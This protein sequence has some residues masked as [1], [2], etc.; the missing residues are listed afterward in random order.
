[1]TAVVVVGGV[2]QEYCAF[3]EWNQI[4]G[5]A[6]R[7]AFALSSHV[8]QITLRTIL[9]DKDSRR[10]IPNFEA[11]GV[12]VVME[13]GTQ[14]IAFDYLH[15]LSDPVIFPR[16]D[17]IVQQPTFSV[18]AEVAI[19]FGM[20]EC[21]PQVSADVCVYDPQSPNHPIGFRQTGGK[22]KRLAIVANEREILKL[23]GT[24]DCDSA[25]TAVLKSE[26]AEIV[27][28]KRGLQGARVFGSAGLLGDVPAYE[29][30]TVF[31]IGSGDV[32]V[33]AFTLAWAVSNLDPIQ[34]ADFASK[35]VAGYV[36]T[37]SLPMISIDEAKSI[38]RSPVVLKPGRVYLA[39]PFRELG[40][41]ILIDEVRSILR[42]LGLDV[43]SPV[44]DIGR[45]PA[46]KVVP[47]D[48]EALRGCDAV[49]AIL[50]GSSPGTLFEVGYAVRGDKPVFCVAQNMRDVDTKLPRGAGCT[51]HPDLISALHLLAWRK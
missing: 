38:A 1:M 25:A 45:G 43:F 13:T 31:T 2:Y 33:A 44:H 8:D 21:T 12:D 6:G 28:V 3:P 16:P 29:T 15:C 4:Y 37:S 24:T 5:S 49:F 11:F 51:V 47:Q 40:Q 20:M 46:E 30:H 39:G 35:A 27:V 18:S 26:N 9:P 7:A 34:A 22:A 48:L 32:F 23:G 42:R 10:I 36:E 50:N 41:R 17:L 19:L 14:L